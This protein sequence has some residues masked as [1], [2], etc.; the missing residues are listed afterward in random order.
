MGSV[1]TSMGY[2]DFKI[3]IFHGSFHRSHGKFHGSG[4]LEIQTSH[5]SFHRTHGKFNGSGDFKISRSMGSVE[6][7][8]G[9]LD[10]KISGQIDNFYPFFT[11]LFEAGLDAWLD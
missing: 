11:M 10:F 9:Y 3:L 5:G 8:M 1:E 7:S 4:D 2:P 6:T